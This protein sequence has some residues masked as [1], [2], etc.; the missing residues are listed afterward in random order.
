MKIPHTKKIQVRQEATG[1]NIETVVEIWVSIPVAPIQD[2]FDSEKYAELTGALDD[3]IASPAI[4]RVIV[5]SEPAGKV[6]VLQ[7]SKS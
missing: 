2:D 5:N 4:D 6:A 1:S 7:T 3:I